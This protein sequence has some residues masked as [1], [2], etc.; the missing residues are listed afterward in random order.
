[1]T[2]RF[3]DFGKPNEIVM[4][5]SLR[6]LPAVTLTNPSPYLEQFPSSGP[7][8]SLAS[9]GS[10]DYPDLATAVANVEPG[11]TLT[12]GPGTYRLEEP[13][14]VG[15]SLRLIG[16]GMN[17]TKIVSTAPGHVLQFE[18]PGTFVA[19]GI[20]FRH[21]GEQP[22]SV[23]SVQGGTIFLR[24]DRFTGAVGGEGGGGAG[25]ILAGDSI[26]IVQES[27]ASFNIF[28]IFV[29]EEA[30]L[31]LEMSTCSDNS[32][33]GIAYTHQ[34]SGLANG[35]MCVRNRN[36]GIGIK[37]DAQVSLEANGF[38][39]NYYAGITYAGQTSGT[40]R[41]N[42]VS[43][44]DSGILVFGQSEPLLE[45]N[46]VTDNGAGIWYYGE[47]GG[48]AR[49]NDCSRNSSGITVAGQSNPVLE[50]NVCNENYYSGLEFQQQASG[51]AKENECSANRVGIRLANDANPELIDNNCHDNAEGD[52]LDE[53]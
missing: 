51:T 45:E 16:A 43:G 3:Y 26:G 34:S 20:S 9:D 2:V 19:E 31:T 18:G 33:S 38:F 39:D 21:L 46:Q 28:G 30:Q 37:D 36:E 42:F 15:E 4:P 13:L 41:A 25:L 8:A 48:V 35:N 10:G 5:E 17:D 52:L 29:V 49:G 7:S 32:W 27:D 53:R 40:A 44:N 12:L 24:Q 47:K 6:A 50:H 1:M 22:A 11:T 14:N 23:L